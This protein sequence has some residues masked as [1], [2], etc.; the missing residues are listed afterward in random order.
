MRRY[1]VEIG[2]SPYVVD[3]QEVTADR[4]Q[5]EV[6]GQ[7]FEVRLS[8]DEDLVE[9]P[10]TPEILPTRGATQ[11]P[12]QPAPWSNRSAAGAVTASPR[13]CRSSPTRLR[14]SPR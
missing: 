13:R 5:V 8:G 6:E 14:T 11:P 2:G 12:A 7:A 4:Y 9:V 10:V 1:T 3:V